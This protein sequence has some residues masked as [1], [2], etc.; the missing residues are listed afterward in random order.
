M[1]PQFNNMS[2]LLSYLESLENRIH[3]LENNNLVLQDQKEFL[4][5]YIDGLDKDR[6]AGTPQDKHCQSQLYQAR[7]CRLGTL[8][9]RKFD[10]IHSHR[11]CHRNRHLFPDATGH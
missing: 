4:T 1:S 11:L 10:H 6:K 7:L 9:R 5:K 8:L 3:T 2:E